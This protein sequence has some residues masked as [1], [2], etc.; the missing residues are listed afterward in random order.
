[1]PFAHG[2]NAVKNSISPIWET[3]VKSYVKAHADSFKTTF[4]AIRAVELEIFTF[5]CHLRYF[6]ST[7][8]Y[9]HIPKS[10]C[11]PRL[12]YFPLKNLI[13][14]IR[15]RMV[16]SYVKSYAESIETISSLIQWPELE[17][18]TVNPCSNLEFFSNSEYNTPSFKY[19]LSGSKF[20]T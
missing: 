12:W 18:S 3:M 2:Q 9:Q 11:L 7:F 13:S 8:G 5:K 17:L 4:S 14:S 19:H 10:L 16:D 6:P 1:M 20:L 15:V